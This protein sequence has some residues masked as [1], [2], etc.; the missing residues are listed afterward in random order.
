MSAGM[1]GAGDTNSVYG[2]LAGLPSCGLPTINGPQTCLPASDRYCM[3]AT[4]TLPQLI[5]SMLPLVC[6]RNVKYLTNRREVT[7]EGSIRSI[8]STIK[9]IVHAIHVH[10]LMCSLLSTIVSLGAHC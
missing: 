8:T 10:V 1:R 4:M 7:R 9:W 2:V 5:S 3:S 6:V